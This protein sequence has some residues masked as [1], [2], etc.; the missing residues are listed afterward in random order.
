GRGRPAR[1]P[2]V[3]QSAGTAAGREPLACGKPDASA[4]EIAAG[5]F[6]CR[7][8]TIGHRP[9]W[10]CRALFEKAMP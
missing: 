8:G 3:R 7:S 6:S 4:A 9:G 10:H 5:R 1:G 2:G